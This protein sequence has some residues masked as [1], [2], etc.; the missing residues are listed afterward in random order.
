MPKI[1][2][3]ASFVKTVE[4]ANVF[5]SKW[6]L[7]CNSKEYY[8]FLKLCLDMIVRSYLSEKYPYEVTGKLSKKEEI[9]LRE[10]FNSDCRKFDSLYYLINAELDLF[11]LRHYISNSDY[12][13]KDMQKEI[14]DN[15][16]TLF[17]QYNFI[18]EEYRIPSGRI[19]I[20]AKDKNDTDVIIELKL[21][22]K[23][24]NRQLLDYATCFNN[25]ILIGITQDKLSDKIKQNNI[26]YYIYD[27]DKIKIQK[28]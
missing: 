3:E 15:F 22:N 1:S 25:P 17:P 16:D 21:H 18:K 2:A 13:E 10:L 26:T 7:L 12:S 27:N 20:L 4:E 14:I 6:I 24:P 5:V 23:N 9:K 19:D 8:K 11:L 28:Y